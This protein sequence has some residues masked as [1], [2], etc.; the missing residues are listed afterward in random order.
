MRLAWFAV[1]VS[2]LFVGYGRAATAAGDPMAA[3][4]GNTL[5]VQEYD[6]TLVLWYRRNHTFTGVDSLG[7]RLAG[8]W[9]LR[10]DQVCNVRTEPAPPP[11]DRSWR[12][13]SKAVSRK[14][15]EQW[16]SV[17]PSGRKVTMFITAGI[18]KSADPMGGF[19]GNTL[20]IS[21][22]AGTL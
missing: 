8:R 18:V 9:N 3:F 16:D 1:A 17:D 6:R 20:M 22:P 13:C 10:G 21:E 12:H 5:Q 11:R 2:A 14:V 4:Y 19:Y 7:N 15:G